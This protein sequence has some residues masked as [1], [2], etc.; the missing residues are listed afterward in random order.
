MNVASAL[1]ACS[2][3]PMKCKPFRLRRL[4]Q[5]LDHVSIELTDNRTEVV[6]ADVRPRS[7]RANASSAS[8]PRDREI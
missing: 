2:E 6:G 7:W 3:F 8:A 4:L 1:S 5:N